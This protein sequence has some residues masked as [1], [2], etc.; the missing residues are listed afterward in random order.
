[1]FYDVQD[2]LDGKKKNYRTKV[3]S[4]E[5][6]QL[7]GYLLCPKCGKLLTGSASKGNGGQYY[8]YHCASSCGARF[9]AENANDLFCRELRKYIPRPGMEK[10]YA[11]VLNTAYK[12]RTKT[13]REEIK[14]IGE[15]IEAA[16]LE[17]AR[18]RKLLLK[19]EID[20]QDFREIKRENEQKIDM[21]ESKLIEMTRV[22]TNIEPMLEK[23]VSN[24][25]HLDQLYKEGD[26]KGKRVFIGSI[27]P[28][29][30]TFDGFQYRTTRVNEAVELIYALDKGFTKN[31][32]GQT[33]EVFDLSSVVARR[34]FELSL[35]FNEL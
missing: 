16:N 7:R 19:E 34:G 17:V 2:F 14:A 9:K 30:L 20:G 26:V 15:Q 33:K 1:L 8:Y 31:E 12:A 24:L 5:I 22:A 32:T 10:A 6:L 21:L 29:K 28:E 23:A 25:G 3:G 11:H 4:Q 35:I 13:Q 18:G 27:Y